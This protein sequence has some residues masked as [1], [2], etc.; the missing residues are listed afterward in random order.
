VFAAYVSDRGRAFI[1]RALYLPKSW[2]GAPERLAAA[3]VPEGPAL[4]TKPRLAAA[5]IERAIAADVPFAW[6]AGASVHGVGAVGM[7]LRRA[8][9]G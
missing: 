5:M 2:T 7:A 9:K 1:D 4:A 6:V 8:Y 3:H